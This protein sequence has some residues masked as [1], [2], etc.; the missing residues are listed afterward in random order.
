MSDRLRS[1]LL[2]F[3]VVILIVLLDQLTKYWA[4]ERLFGQEDIT[5]LPGVF[6]LHF[7]ANNGAAWSMFA[8]Q[9]TVLLLMTVAALG[10]IF[11]VLH[12]GWVDT[13][14][15]RWGVWFV[16]G[17]AIGNFLDRA[18]REGGVVVDFLDFRLIN[19]PIFNIAD[20]FI[21]VGGVLFGIFV[22]QTALRD[23]HRDGNGGDSGDGHGD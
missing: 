3:F 22:L 9:R 18:F 17:G 5:L 16:L 8:G 13:A 11:F 2:P 14:L 23:R 6:Y 7:A 4:M 15:G 21:T 20:V 10:L 19:F 12:R 1:Y